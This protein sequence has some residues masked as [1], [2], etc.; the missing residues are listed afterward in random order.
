MNRN[1][2]NQNIVDLMRIASIR[3]NRS[4]LCSR[5]RKDNTWLGRPGTGYSIRS[6][7]IILQFLGRKEAN[8][9][10]NFQEIADAWYI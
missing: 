10:K 7:L 1:S 5:L 6:I 4:R 3:A 2:R 8:P 9:C